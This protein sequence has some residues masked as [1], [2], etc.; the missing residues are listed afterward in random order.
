MRLMDVGENGLQLTDADVRE[1]ARCRRWRSR[2]IQAE[3]LGYGIQIACTSHL[4]GL[5][6]TPQRLGDL[7]R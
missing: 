7:K 4:A 1:L 5:G 3:Q 2:F 6:E